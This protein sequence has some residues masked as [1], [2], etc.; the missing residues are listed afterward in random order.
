MT[1]EIRANTLKN[2]VGLGTVSFTD[3]GPIVSGIVTANT[4]DGNNLS[5]VGNITAANDGN[6][7][8]QTN[9]ALTVKHITNSAMRANHFIHDDFPSGSG[10]Y[11]IQATESGVTNDRNMCIQGYGGKIKIGAITEPTE[12]LDVTG[13]VKAT[14][15]NLANSIFHTSDTDTLMSFS[16][17]TIK[18]ETAGSERLRINSTGQIIT[19]GN[20][21]PYPTRGLTIRPNTSQTNNYISIIAGNTSSVSG[22]TFGTS[23]DNN[24]NNYRAMFEYYHSGFAHNEGLRFLAL[25]TEKFRIR[26]GS[27]NAGDLL[28]G[29]G[30][31]VIGASPGLLNGLGSHNNANPASVMYGIDDGGGYN[32]M[33]VINFDDGTFNSQRIEFLTGKGGVSMA[34]V[35]MGIDENGLVS[36][37]R[38]ISANSSFN[39]STNQLVVG[40]GVGN[41]GM[42]IYTGASHSGNIIFNDVADGSY[43]GAITYKHG[44]GA[45]DNS[46]RFRTNGDERLRITSNGK[47]NIG[48]GELDQT[49]RMLNV[50]G[51]RVRIGGISSG[52][53]FEIMNS[54]S[55]GSS[56]GMLIQAGANSSDI[57]STFRNT[58]GTTL[59]RIRGDGNV[60]IKSTAP[61]GKLDIQFDGAPSFIT[62]GADADNPK[63]EFFRNTG[64]TPSHYA[65]EFQLLTGDFIF[66]NAGAANLGSHSYTERLRITAH[67]KIKVQG[68]RAGSLQAN[69]DDAL[70][71]YTKS[72]SADINRGVGITFYT[73]DGSGYEM[74]GTIQVAKETAGAN[75]PASYMRFSTQ[76]GSTTTERLRIS[77]SGNMNLGSG[78][79][80]AGLRYLDVQNSSSA[81]NT[82]GSI[83]RLITSNA[84][85]NSTTSVDMVKYKN[86]NFYISNNETSGSTNFN[87]GGS[88]RLRI[89][90]DGQVVINRSSGAVLADSS[91]KLEVFNST[92]NL[93]FVANSTA[94]VSQDAGI[95]FAPANNVY[96]GKIIVTSDEDFSS[97]ANRTAHMGFY[98][99]L[100][101][102]AEERLRISSSGIVHI[103]SVGGGQAVVA[104]GDPDGNSFQAQNRIG[105]DTIFVADESISSAIYMPRQGCFVIITAFSD[106]SGI[107]PQPNTSCIAY[108]DCGASRNIRICDLGTGVGTAVAAKNAYTSNVSDCDNNK[109]TI[110]AGDTQGTFRLVNR[111]SNNDYYYQI[112]FL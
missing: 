54:A 77:S 68:T 24:A 85:G 18:F 28:Y 96:G 45:G 73:H 83:L 106:T 97:S 33:K 66:S 78:A 22:V 35:R 98:T 105:G 37:G 15:I 44:S 71:L 75:N 9:I 14:S 90:S 111:E 29:S 65:S 99:R 4:F 87:I 107:Y 80:I 23:A 49:D 57:N 112:T 19:N 36:I 10:T 5:A 110:M 41:Q 95:I 47:V 31:H 61:R 104:F 91:S 53:S 40:N 16:T 60:G 21:N 20:A 86:G 89:E 67:G 70:Q 59:F 32:G 63:V 17:D 38:T 56:F 7:D 1:S 13:N 69:D 25:G 103:N 76:S 74:G 64:G 81:A 82:H 55:A 94:A 100:N 42:V 12:T 46:F 6:K 84:A 51:G 93:I 79:T 50:Y 48:T 30:D 39:A 92:E 27:S 62:F 58:S 109:L 43:Q 52:N 26:G 34:T 3:S 108:V 102:T 88:N 11:F 2:R 101:G 8:N 72:T